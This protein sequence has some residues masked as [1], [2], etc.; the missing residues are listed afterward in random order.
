MIFRPSCL[1]YSPRRIT[2]TALIAATAL[3]ATACSDDAEDFAP[4]PA[5]E[6]DGIYSFA[7]GCYSIDAADEA[8]PEARFLSADDDT[9]AFETD[10]GD[11]SRFHFKATD[12][13]TYLLYDEDRHYFV[14]DGDGFLRAD[15]ISSDIFE[16]DD[17]YLPGV[18]FEFIESDTS[19]DRLHLRHLKTNQ[20][21]GA[22]QL[23]DD[24]DDAAYVGFHPTDDCA[25]YPELTVDADGEVEKTTFDDGSVFGFVETH[26]HI[27]TNFAFGGAG[28]FH[29]APFHPLGVEHALPSCEMFHGEEGRKDLFGFG[30][31]DGDDLDELEMVAALEQGETFEF[32]HHTDGWPTFTDWPSAHN[33]STHQTQYYKWIERAYL[34]GLRLMVQH[35]TSNQIIC[36]LLA[37]EGIQPTR[38]SC[39]DMVATDRILEET[40]RMERYIDAQH[41]GPGNG[42]FRIVESPEQAR[43]VIEDGNMA[44][45]L[46]IEVSNLF[47]C[48]LVPH[49]GE[50]CDEDDVLEALDHYYDEGVRAL[51][52]VHKYDNAFSAGD[53]HREIIEMGN[54]AQT[55]HWSNFTEDCP[56]VETAFDEGEVA[57]G[58]LNEPRDDYFDP[59]P[60]DMSNFF[61]GPVDKLLE[62]ADRLV[63]DSLPGDWCQ[64]DG[65]TDLGEFLI[66]ELMARGMIIEIDHLPRRSYERAFEM[67]EDAD[68]P[69]VASHG[70]NNHGQL[71]ELGGISKFNFGRCN[72]PDDP[73]ARIADL[74][75]RLELIEDAG[76]FPAEG[77]GFDL[78]GFAGAPGPRFGDNS[79][80]D[81]DQE[82]P[83][84]YPFDSF[85]GD[86]TFDEPQVG[87]R[88]IDFNE[89]GMA[90]I[91]LVPDLIH[92]VRNSGVDS[93]QLEPL[94]KSAEGY[95]RMWERAEE[96]AEAL[97]P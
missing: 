86:V 1:L 47:D 90:H 3:F 64:S 2:A 11:A 60:V 92:D 84:S 16:L 66:D 58:D 7:N 45:V 9:F 24:A 55:G 79:V 25:E 40:R 44:V 52:P 29:G 28:M 39:N 36:E 80:C 34:G 37:G 48:F 93:E 18:Q 20:Y 77:F 71:Y 56:D 5:P 87:E 94:F 21:L 96:R 23:V 49:D 10:E 33:S 22:S 67:L 83:L 19:P 63:G 57:L 72:D 6:H 59:P 78:N 46:G 73:D 26:S 15:E 75:H 50:M 54:F 88:T 62:H 82:D 70:T 4:P 69:A 76:A 30:F 41:G 81:T 89:E 38:Y 35:T 14:A 17:D 27:L 68:Y 42:W 43:E 13:G 85:A 32:N 53:G 61:D 12:L 95:L 91:G 51:F 31:D 97:A 8:Q 74:Q 65:L